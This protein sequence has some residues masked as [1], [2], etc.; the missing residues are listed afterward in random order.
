MIVV[1]NTPLETLIF[2]YHR[3]TTLSAPAIL[4]STPELGRTPLSCDKAGCWQIN[5]I[6][7]NTGHKNSIQFSDI[8]I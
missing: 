1:W 7:A 4:T 8:Y 6:S 3:Q 2:M 5:S